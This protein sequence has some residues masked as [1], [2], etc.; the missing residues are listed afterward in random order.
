[1]R[2]KK[3]MFVL[4]IFSL[5]GCASGP[6]WRHTKIT[7]NVV[8]SRQLVID[9]GNCT[10]FAEGGA[11]I[12][13]V[14]Q[15]DGPKT[16]DIVVRGTT[17][18]PSTG[19]TTSSVYR[20]TASTAPSGG[21]AGG[22][23]NGV[24][25]GASLGAAIAAQRA[26]EKLYKSCMYTKGWTDQPEVAP[27]GNMAASSAK[28]A[29]PKQIKST[30]EPSADI[31]IYRTQDDEWFADL[32]EFMRFYPTYK[33]P[34]AYEILRIE[35]S[36][37]EAANPNLSLS[38]RLV[39]AHYKINGQALTA[40]EK[41][42]EVLM[43]YLAAVGGLSRDQANL[44]FLYAQS[45]D[46][47]IPV[48]TSRSAY[49]SHKSALGGSPIGQLGLGIMLFSGGIQQDKVNGYLWVKKAG[50]SGLNVSNTLREFEDEMSPEQLQAIQ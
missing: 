27:K 20:G 50:A 8:A 26:Q 5:S 11:P 22:F 15:L 46:S 40:N 38:Q 12:P 33:K 32:E 6:D 36:K 13:E 31:K 1:M 37:L 10:L 14:A 47:R 35:M 43:I 49:W 17:F 19:T 4:A 45:K 7:D 41:S 48:N 16:T 44:G 21:F 42:D 2:Q 18:N 30:R 29:T 24:A 9:D 3:W 25:S 23:A 39:K 28:L 34:A